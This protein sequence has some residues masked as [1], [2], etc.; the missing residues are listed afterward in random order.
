MGTIKKNLFLIQI[1]FFV[2]VLCF[3]ST[4][5]LEAQSI[6]TQQKARKLYERLAGVKASLNHPKVQAMAQVYQQSPAQAASIATQDPQFLNITVK[7]MALKMSTREESIAIPFN[8]FAASVMGIVRDQTDARQLLTGNFYYMGNPT[9]LPAS[10]PTD[11]LQDVVRTNRHY[12]ALEDNRTIDVGQTL[13]RMEGQKLLNP[14]D[15]PQT[16]M[17]NPDPA[18]VLTSRAF[19]AAHSVAGTNRRPVEYSFRQFMCVKIEEWADTNAS[20]LR[21]GRDIDRFPG[22]DHQKFLSSCMGCHTVMDGFRGAFAYWN[23]DG[24][25]IINSQALQPNRAPKDLVMRKM[26]QNSTVFPAGFTMVDNSFVNNANRG[27]NNLM[28]GW[29]GGESTKG[30]GVKDFGKL[31]SES[32]RYSQCLSLRVYESVCKTK[33]QAI[34]NMPMLQDFANSLEKNNYNLKKLFE[35]V[36]ID[37][38]CNG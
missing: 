10:F 18:G 12:E 3:F 23:F 6:E 22:G 32:K 35:T 28:F 26:N 20:D 34:Y 1:K 14:N 38:R 24:Q 13:I 15:D 19:M 7:Q 16:L 30:T 17:N 27:N 37:P 8:D 2:T 21:I 4:S 29:R 36:A 31:L 5:L 25:G 33:V 9:L 11:I